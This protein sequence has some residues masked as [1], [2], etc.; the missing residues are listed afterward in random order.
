MEEYFK[1]GLRRREAL[2]AFASLVICAHLVDVTGR[3]SAIHGA[4]DA[5]ITGAAWFF[6]CYASACGIHDFTSTNLR[7]RRTAMQ[8]GDHRDAA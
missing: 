8:G 6:L 2:A 3:V 7:N 5:V 1:S 4:L